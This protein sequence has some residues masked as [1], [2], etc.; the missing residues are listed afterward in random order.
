M[1]DDFDVS[2]DTRISIMIK[3]GV[4]VE[5]KPG[6]GS[7]MVEMEKIA[8][9]GGGDWG[10]SAPQSLALPPQ[11]ILSLSTIWEPGRD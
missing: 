2:I 6:P 7:Q 1:C 11:A 5:L 4:R 9:V 8:R 10:G 3:V